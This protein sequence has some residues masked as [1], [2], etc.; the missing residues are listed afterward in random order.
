MHC[1]SVASCGEQRGFAHQPQLRS[2]AA[3][4]RAADVYLHEA[5]LEAYRAL[6]NALFL[7]HVAASSFLFSEII[8]T[9][10]RRQ[11]LE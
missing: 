10:V 2:S 3:F 11:S 9:H 4:I 5:I 1:I 8:I 7:S 6:S